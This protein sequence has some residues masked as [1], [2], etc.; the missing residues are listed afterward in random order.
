MNPDR[1][2]TLAQN[3]AARRVQEICYAEPG[4]GHWVVSSLAPPLAHSLARSCSYIPFI[5][6]LALS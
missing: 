3:T 2:P 5:A 6:H 4:I 1:L